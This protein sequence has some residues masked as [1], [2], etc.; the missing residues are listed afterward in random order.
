MDGI[1]LVREKCKAY[2]PS[3][4]HARRAA[5]DTE[6][7]WLAEHQMQLS[8]IVGAVK[9]TTEHITVLGSALWR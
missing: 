8:A 2:W 7:Q 1:M 3:Y 5:G 9:V 4:A 6:Q